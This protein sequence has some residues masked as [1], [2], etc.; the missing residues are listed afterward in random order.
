LKKLRVRWLEPASLDLIG[1]IEFIQLDRPAVAR[2]VGRSILAAAMHLRDSPRRGKVVPELLDMGISDYRQIL[3][4][5]YRVICAVRAD[6]LDIEAVIDSR[7]DLQT[8][9]FER[10]IR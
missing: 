4:P 7:R 8:W 5:P 10:L 1:I 3:V 6:S 2:E 9:L